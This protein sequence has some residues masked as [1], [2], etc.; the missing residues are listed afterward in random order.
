MEFDHEASRPV[1]HRGKHGRNRTRRLLTAAGVIAVVA[2]L[3]VGLVVKDAASQTR[4]AAAPARAQA[5]PAVPKG[6]KLTFDPSFAGTKLNTKLWAT[7]YWWSPKGCT[8]NPTL[9]KEWYLPSQVSVSGGVLHLTA[10]HKTT[11]GRAANGAPKSYTC[12]SGMVTSAP[13]FNFKYGVMQIVARI[14]YGTGLWPALW[15]AAS[16]YQWPPEI[17]ILEHWHSEQQ[18]KVYVHPVV[19][20]Y[21]GGAVYTP[22]NL[23]AGW[24]TFTLTWTANR[25]TWYFD[26]IQVYTETSYV[27]QQAMYFVANVADDSTA[28]NSC[29]GTMLIKSVKVWQP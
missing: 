14:P 4:Q 21:F 9:E 19:G 5:A 11:A 25:V 17:D 6:W 27:P 23:S 20:H 26:G 7:C 10:Q 28:A 29:T 2:A 1:R 15:L 12:R 13:G 18:A 3:V 22:G 16:N 8:N 24:H